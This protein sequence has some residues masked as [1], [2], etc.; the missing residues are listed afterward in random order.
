[1]D[2]HYCRY[3][4]LTPP[5]PVPFSYFLE[6]SFSFQIV[7]GRVSF[8]SLDNC[9]DIAFFNK[10]ANSK[11]VLRSFRPALTSSDLDDGESREHH[12]KDQ[13]LEQD[14]DAVTE[15]LAHVARVACRERNA[16]ASLLSTKCDV[17]T[18]AAAL[19]ALEYAHQVTN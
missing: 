13:Q 4:F 8:G 12:P 1:M 19:S 3:H 6:C 2:A 7:L 11:R 5:L 16:A 18:A 9:Y 10:A 17:V 15:E 14:Y